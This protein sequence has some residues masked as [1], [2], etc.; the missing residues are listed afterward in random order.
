[1]AV[2]GKL[3]DKV[4]NAP[5]NLA[6]SDLRKLVEQLGWT[7]RK[8]KGSHYI[9]SH[10]QAGSGKEDSPRPLNL[11]RWKGGKAEMEQA[12]EVLKRARAMG[13]IE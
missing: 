6:F 5:A 7:L 3:L 12:K 1:M 13:L 9:F 10:P 4:R 2:D 11:Q 8:I